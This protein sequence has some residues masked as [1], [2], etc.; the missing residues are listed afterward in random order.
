[1][2]RV[3]LVL[4]VFAIIACKKT[5]I[6]KIEKIRNVSFSEIEIEYILEDSLLNV[7]ALEILKGSVLIATSEGQTMVKGA[8]FNHFKSMFGLD[9]IHKPNFRAIKYNGKSIFTLS[10]A[11]PA[12]L[13]KD[14]KL[15]YTETNDK[16]FY[17]SM[18]FW[19]E[20]EG[21]AIGDPT[22]DCLSIII[23]RDGGE[24][25]SKLSCDIAPKTKEGEAAFAAS[26]TNI[27]IIGNHTWV[28]TGGTASRILYSPDKG[29]TW[30]VFDT[31]IIQGLGTTGIYS[32]DFYDENI[33][34]AVGGDYTKPEDNTGNKMHT[35]DGGK[36]WELVAQGEVP[37]YRSCVQYV[38]NSNAKEL[39][40]VG[41]EGIDYSNDSGSSWTHLSDEG[42]YTL[43]F[44]NDSVA[45]AGGNGRVVK[46]KFN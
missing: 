31:P 21:I 3:V 43:R 17:D 32:I 36:T 46:L 26:D 19:N 7:R 16:A 30:E 40:A 45:Y 12:L 41:F 10:I 11:S 22:D 24:S 6:S 42:F 8:E 20:Q 14:G 4:L 13:Y 18:D 44:L 9:T 38:P 23:T 1:M 25:W 27:K 5:S 15:V 39:V 34:F 28:A 2:S 33:G 37:G 29:R 35:N